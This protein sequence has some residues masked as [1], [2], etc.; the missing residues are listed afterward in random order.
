MEHPMTTHVPSPPGT[1]A[2]GL[3]AIADALAPLDPPEPLLVR[4][5][6]P[7][8]GDGVE[9]GLLPVYE[10]DPNA[11]HVVDLLVGF[12]APAPWWGLGLVTGGRAFPRS[13]G[14]AIDEPCHVSICHL[15]ART[16]LVASA[17]HGLDLAA[18]PPVGRI[19][20]LLQRSLG[21]P[22]GVAAG[23]PGRWV[24]QQWLDRSLA[25][26]GA[27][28]PRPAWPDL[29]ALHPF[30]GAIVE[31]SVLRGM[32][33]LVDARGWEALLRID[34]ASVA[35]SL[36][37]HDPEQI[38]WRLLEWVGSSTVGSWLSAL[39]PS[40]RELLDALDG[41]V[42]EATMAEVRA[43]LLPSRSA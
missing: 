23:G 8:T 3:Q 10:L 31:P 7:D 16:G 36:A 15:A 20:D 27:P 4:L 42:S 17:V 35:E 25:L 26:A 30:G 38:G 39:L 5:R 2:A 13:E 43:A 29:A 41:L 1:D 37:F 14:A 33:S 18:E 22:L 24:E 32:T 19:P 11:H 21:L 28:G 9:I 12:E 40:R 6:L 34:P